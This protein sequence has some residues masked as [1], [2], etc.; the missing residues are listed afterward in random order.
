MWAVILVKNTER[1][2]QLPETPAT[3]K[4][5]VP[6]EQHCHATSSTLHGG[7]AP[8]PACLK[9]KHAC[10]SKLYLGALIS[11]LFKLAQLAEGMELWLKVYI[12]LYKY[13]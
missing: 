10:Y 1:L 3:T 11:E 9:K 4:D 7:T 13:F 2:T 12:A 8:D 5:E 6:C